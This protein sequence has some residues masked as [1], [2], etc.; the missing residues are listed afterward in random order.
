MKMRFVNATNAANR[1]HD[2]ALRMGSARNTSGYLVFLITLREWDFPERK[3]MF[4]SG[5]RTVSEDF[6]AA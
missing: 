2:I 6:S 1:D 3:N 5:E 4:F